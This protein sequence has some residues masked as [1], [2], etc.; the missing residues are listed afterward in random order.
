MDYKKQL[1]EK[2]EK[3][4]LTNPP[5]GDMNESRPVREAETVTGCRTSGPAI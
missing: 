3:I 1:V 4:C 5:A 2:I